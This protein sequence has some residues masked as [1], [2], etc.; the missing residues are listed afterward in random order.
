MLTTSGGVSQIRI[1][2]E[3]EYIRRQRSYVWQNSGCASRTQSMPAKR[4]F[5]GRWHVKDR[6]AICISQTNNGGIRKYA[7][8]FLDSIAEK[9]SAP[10]GRE[11]Y[12]MITDFRSSFNQTGLR[13]GC[14]GPKSPREEKIRGDGG[15]H[16]KS[17]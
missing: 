4:S 7:P 2:V 6:K 1:K 11:G 3:G 8:S 15:D 17:R 14:T 12:G 16:R 5:L 9:Q 13:V 10:V